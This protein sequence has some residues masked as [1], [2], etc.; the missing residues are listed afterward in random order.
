[1]IA[2]RG[3]S[4]DP[5]GRQ[6]GF[7]EWLGPE[8]SPIFSQDPEFEPAG[9]SNPMEDAAYPPQSRLR[10]RRESRVGISGWRKRCLYIILILLLITVITNLALTLWILKVMD[11]SVEGM[12]RLKIISE[13]LLLDGEAYVLD[14]LVASH[15]KSR[16][17]VPLVFEGSKNI[18]FYARRS[19]SK[20]QNR[21]TLGQPQGW[22]GSAPNF[23]AELLDRAATPEFGVGLAGGH[24]E[25]QGR[26][27][28]HSLGFGALSI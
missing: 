13:G 6:S 21:L 26:H 17:G 15:I 3:S 14:R 9:Y 5:S 24:A 11:F 20:L 10:R 1:M 2:H 19:G 8:A 22:W 12:G 18:T 16:L 23:R 7:D 25:G 27:W 28:E 4:R